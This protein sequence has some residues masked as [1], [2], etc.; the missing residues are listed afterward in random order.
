MKFEVTGLAELE[1]AAKKILQE[2]K[3]EKIFL[4]Y[5][6]M[7][8]GK[9]TLI[10]KI[11]QLLGTKDHTSS[12]TFSIVN[13]YELESGSIYHF[14]FY[15][16]KNQNEAFDMGY[17]DYFYSGNYCFV[18]WPEKIADLLPE[19]YVKVKIEALSEENRLI[20]VNTI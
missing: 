15:R 14:D 18:E 19:H 5:G 17:E 20:E 11:C 3:E 1:L 4:F 12:P 10:N 9:T 6:G 8:A 16:L 2:A 7:G 13:E